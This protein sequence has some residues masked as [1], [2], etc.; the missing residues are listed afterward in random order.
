M[1]HHKWKE[2]KYLFILYAK[3]PIGNY[4]GWTP[5]EK[6][7]WVA[8]CSSE[9]QACG[10]ELQR[11]EGRAGTWVG[12]YPKFGSGIQSPETKFF[13]EAGEAGGGKHERWNL[14]GHEAP[15]VCGH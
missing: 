10:W 1:H 4:R 6:S 13:K 14:Q 5:N 8:L 11:K 9:V 15:S 7:H 2:V 12:E 3:Q